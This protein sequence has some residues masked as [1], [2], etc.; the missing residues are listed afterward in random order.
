MHACQRWNTSMK[1]FL[2]NKVLL[3]LILLVVIGGVILELKYSRRS[4]IAGNK[5]VRDIKFLYLYEMKI[6]EGLPHPDNENDLFEQERKKATVE[7]LH[8]HY[9]YKELVDPDAKVLIDLQKR[10]GNEDVYQPYQ[11]KKCGG[12][13]P[14]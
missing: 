4:P 10:F 5:F 9:F 2:R 11:A 1:F 6:R 12:F 7:V 3:L 8:G 13:H 14:D